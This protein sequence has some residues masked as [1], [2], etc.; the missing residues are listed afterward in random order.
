MPVPAPG[1]IEP[2]PIAVLD[3]YDPPAGLIGAL[4]APGLTRVVFDDGDGPPPLDGLVVRMAGSEGDGA[5][6]GPLYACLGPSYW[7]LPPAKTPERARRVLISGGGTDPI[8]FVAA[9][10]DALRGAGELELTVALAAAPADGLD[11][12]R[13]VTGLDTLRDELIAADL[14]VC[15]A[16]QTM[17]ESIA[18]G[19]PCVAV[20]IAENQRVQAGA[21]ADRGC[22]RLAGSAEEAAAAAVRLAG[23]A[24]ARGA[25]ASRGQEAVDGYGALRVAFAAIRAQ[26]AA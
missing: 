15:A 5:L 20:A 12:D 18:C 8:G 26:P 16:G 11:A 23:D 6:A 14:V 24:A 7:G 10:A 22:V 2:G 19:T 13:L 9:V 1:G 25:L 21:L 4:A 3:A 17:L